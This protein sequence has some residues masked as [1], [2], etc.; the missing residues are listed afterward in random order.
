MQPV[1]HT[2]VSRGIRT[3]AVGARGT[4][5][6][7]LSEFFVHLEHVDPVALEDGAEGVVADDLLFVVRVLHVVRFDMDPKLFDDL[8]PRKLLNSKKGSKWRT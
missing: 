7:S 3:G 2:G 1:A 5:E 6:D 8:R 4:G